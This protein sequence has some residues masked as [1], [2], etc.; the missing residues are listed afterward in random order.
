MRKLLF[1]LL[2]ALTLPAYAWDSAGHRLISA[3]AYANLTPAA[4]QAVDTL[5]LVEDPDYPPTARFLYISTLPDVWRKNN[6]V[7]ASWHF[8]SQ[9][10]SNDGTPTQP[11][12]TPNLLTA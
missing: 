5:T 6:P 7:T 1:L 4:K 3:V 2:I 12:A 11:A 10:W 9:P 8:I